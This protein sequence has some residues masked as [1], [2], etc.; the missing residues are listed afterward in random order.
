MWRR[1]ISALRHKVGCCFL[2]ML[3]M[4]CVTGRTTRTGLPEVS[5]VELLAA[6]HA[7]G[8]NGRYIESLAELA[9]KTPVPVVVAWERHQVLVP[10]TPKTTCRDSHFRIVAE[11]EAREGEVGLVL[12]LI[13]ATDGIDFS[14][15]AGT[16][17]ESLPDGGLSG[18][19]MLLAGGAEGRI[20]RHNGKS[21]AR[22]LH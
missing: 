11:R 7:E 9:Q 13:S 17:N 15:Y 2:V 4:A 20:E 18:G 6:L 14:A 5:C 12:T 1:G 16:L 21:R 3:G 8:P 10:L 22:L 19:S